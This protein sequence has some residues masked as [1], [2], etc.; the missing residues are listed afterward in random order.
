MIW[1]LGDT[2]K[3]IRFFMA[4]DTNPYVGK[5]GLTGITV[6]YALETDTSLQTLSSPTI[7]EVGAGWYELTPTPALVGTAGSLILIFSASGAVTQQMLLQVVAFDPYDSNALGLGRLDVAVSTRSTLTAADVWSH[8]V[9]SLTT[10]PPYPSESSIAAAVWSEPARTLTSLGDS[11]VDEIWNRQRSA[12]SRPAGSFGDYLDAAVSSVGG[13]PDASTIANA[14]WSHASRTLTSFGTLSAD[15]ALAVWQS[16]TTVNYGTDT[17]GEALKTASGGVVDYNTLANAVWSYSTRSLTTFGTLVVDIW[18]SPVRELTG[19]GS[20]PSDVAL[21]VWQSSSTTDYGTDSMG[22]LVKAGVSGGVDYGSLA[23]AVWSHST[24]QIT[25]MS[26]TAAK[27]VW[28]VLLSVITAAGSIGKLVKDNLDA[29]VSSRSTLT[30][31]DVQSAL[32]AQGYTSSRAIR[33]D[34][35]DVAVSTRLASS[36]YTAPAN[37]DILAIRAK[38]DQLSFTSGNVHAVAQVVAD[39]SGYALSTSATS[40]LVASL[41]GQTV[42]GSYSFVQWL[43]LI[44]AVLFGNRTKSGSTETYYDVLSSNA[45]VV[46]TVDSSGNRTIS[47]LDGG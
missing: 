32:D 46:G 39:K 26:S 44:G 31:S 27:A 28:D 18:S 25:D 1:K 43:R 41:F 22:E 30:A 4:D 3:K 40:A 12:V 42:E 15:T 19:Y 36:S 13:G 14:V 6:N 2:S 23:A 17:M 38:T 24:R 5:T 47:L 33:L 21:A 34:N 10:F 20:L 8:S 11:L 45:R 7:A 9:R 37:A 35:L 29:A 16:S